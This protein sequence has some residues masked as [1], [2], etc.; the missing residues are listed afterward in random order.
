[1]RK[2]WNDKALREK[3]VNQEVHL[4][5][6]NPSEMKTRLPCW[7][8]YNDKGMYLHCNLKSSDKK[9]QDMWNNDLQDVENQV[10]ENN[11]PGE[12]KNG[13]GEPRFFHNMLQVLA[14]PFG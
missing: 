8:R 9:G 7:L 14:D 5:Q 4:Q 3:A 1:M 10:K 12:N 13:S 6:D 11:H 2:E